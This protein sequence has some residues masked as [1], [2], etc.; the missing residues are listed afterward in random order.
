MS[1]CFCFVFC[2]FCFQEQKSTTVLLLQDDD[3]WHNEQKH[4]LSFDDA[5]IHV[6]QEKEKKERVD[7]IQC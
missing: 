5:F 1:S 6:M 4:I 3:S 7:N 2:L